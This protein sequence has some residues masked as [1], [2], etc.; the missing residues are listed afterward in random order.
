MVILEYCE[1]NSDGKFGHL[2]KKHD[3]PECDEPTSRL[4]GQRPSYVALFFVVLHA[5]LT[6]LVSAA[7]WG[8]PI[9]WQVRQNIRLCT[10]NIANANVVDSCFFF[11]AWSRTCCAR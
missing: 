11:R 8:L 10:N 2:R 4:A 3:E 6:S 7:P 9:S 5:Y 1:D